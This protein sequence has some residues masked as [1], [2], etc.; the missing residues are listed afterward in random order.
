ML[1]RKG[2]REEREAGQMRGSEKSDKLSQVRWEHARKLGKVAF[3]NLF[4]L[5]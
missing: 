4:S 5:S 2:G 1:W 3:I